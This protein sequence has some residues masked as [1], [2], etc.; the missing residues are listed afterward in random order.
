MGNIL[1]WMLTIEALGLAA[2]PL[3]W[4]ALPQ[5]HACAVACAK[6]VGV[7]LVGLIAWAGP[8]SGLYAY[9]PATLLAAA[10]ACAIVLWACWGRGMIGSL[11]RLAR[12]E[13]LLICVPE[14][15]FAGAAIWQLFMVSLNPSL[16]L[17]EI[18]MNFAFVNALNRSQWF[19]PSDPWLAGYPINYYYFGH[20]LV[21]LLIRLSGVEPAVGFNLAGITFFACVAT[22]IF[23]IVFEV[24]DLQSGGRAPLRRR[25]LA[26]LGAVGMALFNGNL[27]PLQRLA[28]EPMLLFSWWARAEQNW[29]R[30]PYHSHGELSELP[31]RTY[32]LHYT[33]SFD[34]ALP[35]M[36]VLFVCG[37]HSWSSG[38]AAGRLVPDRPAQGASLANEGGLGQ[39]DERGIPR[40][41]LTPHFPKSRRLSF[42]LVLAALWAGISLISLWVLPAVCLS[43]GALAL[44]A[45]L[46]TDSPGG[47]RRGVV[48]L[49]GWAGSPAL[50]AIL[51]WLLASRYWP[52]APPGL[53]YI[54]TTS[55]ARAISP[56][57]LALQFGVPLAGSGIVALGHVRALRAEFWV[58]AALAL[59]GI[60]ALWLGI[61]AAI[62]LLLWCLLVLV[63]VA[64]AKGR[65][66]VRFSLL[67]LLVAAGLDVLPFFV[68]VHDTPNTLFKFGFLAWVISAIG[69]FAE[70]GSLRPSGSRRSRLAGRAA[71][72]GA[73]AARFVGAWMPALA[74]ATTTNWL[75]GWGIQTLDGV[76]FYLQRSAPAEYEA[77]RWLNSRSDPGA[78]LLEMT[79]AG[80]TPAGRMS[81]FTG[82]PAVV[83][84]YTHEAFW[85][86]GQEAVQKE[87]SRRVADVHQVYETFDP[88]E[89]QC[90]IQKYGVVYVV[91]GA[92][93]RKQTRPSGSAEQRTA[94]LAKFGHFMDVAYPPAGSARDDAVIIFQRRVGSDV[95]CPGTSDAAH[96]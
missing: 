3:T 60:A 72:A 15:V 56:R 65:G 63:V 50:G 91:V 94:A 10:T 77:V 17:S 80:F 16:Y 78:V 44:T 9:T 20:F 75:R 86:E 8:A 87:I 76:Y 35:F 1:W 61:S 21:A 23:L 71:L 66:E 32:L 73:A 89:A 68:A 64:Y 83:G 93:E 55:A 22:L 59:G 41:G 49:A 13:L 14:I 30:L 69:L 79:A 31:W 47:A 2:L 29:W 19:P 92:F 46:S 28:A 96:R 74:A 36:L 12:N 42:W 54:D 58:L 43:A 85:H 26:G 53:L 38:R 95:T 7:L 39:H 6:P 81:A 5:R 34:M 52:V 27:A 67:L 24:V 62:F 57:V 82:M 37:L 88:V 90:L 48:G 25:V 51:V 18:P 45:L 40:R 4:A 33:H 84:W 70:L 11:R